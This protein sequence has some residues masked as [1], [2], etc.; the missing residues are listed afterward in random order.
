MADTEKA[1][2]YNRAT[3]YVKGIGDNLDTF[4]GRDLLLRRFSI[5]ER[6]MKGKE[7][8][9]VAMVVSE[10]E[11]GIPSD[12]LNEVHAWSRSLADK[13]AEI[14]ESAL[15]VVVSFV[16]VPTSSGFKVWSIA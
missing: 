6:P 13:L 11:A 16:K 8:A 4:Q 9:F 10:F 15:P 14:P 1:V 7:T 3:E 12:E 2:T 5:S